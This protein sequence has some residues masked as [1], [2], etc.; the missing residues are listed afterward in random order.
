MALFRYY[1]CILITLI[2]I[3]VLGV[4]IIPAA[5][6]VE[7]KPINHVF[8]ISVGGLNRE[9]FASNPT[10]NMKYL[11]LEGAA[12]D[13]ILA[14]RADTMEAA[15]ASLLTGAMPETHKHLTANDKVEVESIFDLF[16]KNGKSVLTVDGTGG[17]LYSFAYGDKEYLKMEAHSSSK[18]IMEEGFKRFSQNKPFFSYLYIDECSDALLRQDQDAYY[19]AIRNFDTQLGVFLKKIKDSGL[20]DTSLIIVTSARSSSS[21]NLVPLIISGPGCSVNA[22]INGGMIID[23]AATICRLT[24]LENTAA[25]R[26]L[27]LY[28]ALTVN[29][30]E[31]QNFYAAW[32]R[33]LQKDR[34][35]NWN[36]LYRLEDELGRTV[37][38]MASIK[39][40]KQSVFD[41]AGEREQ[42]IIGL[43]SK[44][45]VE[46]AIVAVILLLMT[47]GYLLEYVILKRKF[48]LFK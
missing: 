30:E 47:G 5:A 3:G 15:E 4:E 23:I 38:Q 20:L 9:G 28:G 39:E 7:R 19:H 48:L 16:K 24:G 44:L 41:F 31:R 6:A 2:L 46:R 43:K 22:G 25:S 14:I 45:T 40:E 33:D 36:G 13:K 8:L 11:M 26:G 18:V 17:K 34:Q 29:E 21:S 12:S 27:P 37:R 10:P 42:L 1:K 35:A 32:I